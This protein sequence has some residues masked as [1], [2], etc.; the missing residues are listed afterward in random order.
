MIS[1]ILRTALVASALAATVQIAHA[2]SDPL[3]DA[4]GTRSV[5]NELDN[6]GQIDD[7]EELDEAQ[8]TPGALSADDLSS[9]LANPSPLAKQSFDTAYT[10]FD[11]KLPGAGNEYSVATVF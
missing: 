5:S 7:P 6:P 1:S 4:D 8:D 10:A 3:L 9:E 2:Q 11:G